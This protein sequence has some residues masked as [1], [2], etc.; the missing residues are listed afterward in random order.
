VQQLERVDLA[1]AS[2]LVRPRGDGATVGLAAVDPEGMGVALIQSNFAGWGTGL[3]VD[4]IALHNR[5]A[6]FSL[7]EGDLAEYAPGRRPPH[8]L[9]P[10]LVCR[11]DG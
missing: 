8:T 10:L 9:S 6:A 2:E 1:H 5:G 3:F 4:G 11:P 7:H